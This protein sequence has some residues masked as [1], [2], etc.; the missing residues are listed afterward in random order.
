MKG[1]VFR[2]ILLKLSCNT[3][4]STYFWSLLSVVST[5]QNE[6]HLGDVL[7]LSIESFITCTSLF[8]MRSLVLGLRPIDDLDLGFFELMLLKTWAL[9]SFYGF[10]RFKDRFAKLSL[11]L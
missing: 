4:L 7:M 5:K 10:F 1:P 8:R 6:L 2:L 9:N 11:Y 3:L